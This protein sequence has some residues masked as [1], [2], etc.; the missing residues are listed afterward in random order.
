MIFSNKSIKSLEGSFMKPIF[1][2]LRT[3]DV[4]FENPRIKRIY[5]YKP[6]D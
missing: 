4:H 2:N 1:K 5:F 6:G 3:R